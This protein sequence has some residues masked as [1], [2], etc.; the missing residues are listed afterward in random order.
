MDV[1]WKHQGNISNKYEDTD[2]NLLSFSLCQL[3]VLDVDGILFDYMMRK[4]IESV[5]F[6]I[7][8]RRLWCTLKQHIGPSFGSGMPLKFV[9]QPSQLKN[10][11]K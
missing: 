3:S 7:D 1:I 5:H 9:Y 10:K 6:S 8:A 11:A 4:K 2:I